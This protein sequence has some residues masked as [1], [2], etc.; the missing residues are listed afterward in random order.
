M[1]YDRQL[2]VSTLTILSA[3]VRYP[4]AC[5]VVYST[6]QRYATVVSESK[7]KRHLKFYTCGLEHVALSV[8]A[9][10]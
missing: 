6:S 8:S 5:A 4:L 1:A 7:E 10:F 2:M 9:R 3:G